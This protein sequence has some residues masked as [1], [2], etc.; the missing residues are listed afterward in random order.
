MSMSA[1]APQH[2]HARYDG[3]RLSADDYLAL[4][5][6]GFR[7]ELIDGVVRM[8]PS[9]SFTHQLIAAEILIQ[10]GA[11]LTKHPIGVATMEVDIK[12][13]DGCVYR[14]DV[15][16]LNSEKASRCGVHVTEPPD[17]IVEVI[18]V[19]SRIDDTETK[20]GRYEAAGVGEYWLIDPAREELTFLQHVAG[21]YVEMTPSQDGF[22]SSAIPGFRLDLS[23]IRR[24]F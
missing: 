20:R 21:R 18:S 24:L 8:S 13:A 15:V 12:L 14:P 6:D 16:F 11:Y 3:W 10:I 22:D 2:D 17:L 5:P 23:R 4:P 19:E 9:A 1:I 7:Y